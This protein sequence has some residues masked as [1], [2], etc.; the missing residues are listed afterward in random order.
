MGEEEDPTLTPEQTAVVMAAHHETHC[1]GVEKVVV[2]P[3]GM[4][5]VP[6]DGKRSPTKDVSS[7]NPVGM[8]AAV[9]AASGSG[10]GEKHR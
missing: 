8:Q 5:P 6:V 1:P 9:E 10:S 4:P 7:G 2:F 3:A